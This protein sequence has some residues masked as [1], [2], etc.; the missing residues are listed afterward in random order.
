MCW[1][2]VDEDQGA[3]EIEEEEVPRAPDLVSRIRKDRW[4]LR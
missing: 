2:L 4:W 3:V 1:N